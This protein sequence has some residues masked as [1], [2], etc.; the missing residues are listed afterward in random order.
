MGAGF[1]AL[2]QKPPKGVRVLTS[3]KAGQCSYEM[4]KNLK[5]AG[6]NIDGGAFLSYIASVRPSLVGS[7]Q[8]PDSPFPLD[9]LMTVVA[10][11]TAANVKS[12]LKSEQ[13]PQLYGMLAGKTVAY[14]PKATVP[15]KLKVDINAEPVYKLGVADRSEIASLLSLP[16]RVPPIKKTDQAN[17]LSFSNLPPF[18]KKTLAAFKDDG[19]ETPLR[20]F[21]KE[22]V[23]VLIKHNDAFAETM[24][25]PPANPQQKGQFN[26]Q[27]QNRQMALAEVYADLEAKFEELKALAPKRENENPRWKANYDYV[28]ARLQFRM[29]YFYEY[30]AM[31]GKVRKDDLPAFEKDKN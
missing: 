30:N 28:L 25:P 31:L 23:D 27:I 10:T 20:Q 1:D 22:A 15:A 17:Q 3:C 16:N 6:A 24:G 13:T 21:V 19:K 8:K 26:N 5:N 14:D 9:D 12:Y 2:L 7:D 4:V 29:A 11:K 18:A